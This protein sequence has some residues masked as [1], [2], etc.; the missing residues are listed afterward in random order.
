MRNTIYGLLCFFLM[1]ISSQLFAQETGKEEG[2]AAP[3]AHDAAE[4]A[5]SWQTR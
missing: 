3:G 2:K 1:H 5:K 4:L